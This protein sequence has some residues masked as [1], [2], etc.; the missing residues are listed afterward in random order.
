MANLYP[1]FITLKKSKLKIGSVGM[2]NGIRMMVGNS[3]LILIVS[4]YLSESS[5]INLFPICLFN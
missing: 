2:I 5:V 1:N 3:W 4:K